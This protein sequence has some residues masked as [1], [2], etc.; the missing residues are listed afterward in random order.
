MY[1]DTG[2]ILLHGNGN[3]K[4]GLPDARIDE[5]ILVPCVP[6]KSRIYGLWLGFRVFRI[7]G[8]RVYRKRAEST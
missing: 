7:L 4:R 2:D 8:F 5:A 6:G 1:T 3:F